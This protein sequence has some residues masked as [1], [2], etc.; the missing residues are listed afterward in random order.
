MRVFNRATRAIYN[1]TK[2]T[3][4]L[5]CYSAGSDMRHVWFQHK[6]YWPFQTNE[7]ANT[8]WPWEVAHFD[9]SIDT[10]EILRLPNPALSDRTVRC[11]N[12]SVHA[13]KLP[14]VRSHSFFT[15]QLV[16][17]VL[18]PLASCAHPL[19]CPL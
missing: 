10:E 8:E 15:T 9:D 14:Q 11:R 1:V 6:H 17:L 13:R 2:S 3:G 12:I 7:Y 18:A 16:C 4:C 5:F 19:F